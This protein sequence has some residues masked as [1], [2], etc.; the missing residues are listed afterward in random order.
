VLILVYL[1]VLIVTQTHHVYQ[2][3]QL[4][5]LQF[6]NANANKDSLE[7]VLIV[8][9]N[10]VNMESVLDFMDLTS[11]LLDLACVLALLPIIPTTLEMTYVN[12]QMEDKSFIKMGLLFVFLLENVSLKHGNVM[13]KITLKSN[14]LIQADLDMKTLLL[15]SKLVFVIMAFK[16]VMNTLALVLHQRELFTL[17]FIMEMFVYLLRNVQQIGIALGLNLALSL[18]VNLLEPV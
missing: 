5:S 4:S 9:L 6:I 2:H 16:E 14:V 11:A 3:I 7:M 13:Y 10:L 15:V 8:F 1:L 17:L 12:A 18:L